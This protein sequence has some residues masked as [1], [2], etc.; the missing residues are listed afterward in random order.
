MLHQMQAFGESFYSYWQHL[1]GKFRLFSTC[2]AEVSLISTG[3][4]V[5]Q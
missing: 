3:A 1:L 2:T 5:E 4:V